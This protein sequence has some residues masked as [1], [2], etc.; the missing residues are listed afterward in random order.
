MTRLFL[1]MGFSILLNSMALAWWLHPAVVTVT[2]TTVTAYVINNFNQ[3][4]YCE[5][6]VYGKTIFNTV[7]YQWGAGIIEPGEGVK[8]QVFT[9]PH[10]PFKQ[11]WAQI[12]CRQM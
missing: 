3:N 8:L 5:G 7:L 6:N 10:V 9:H 1:G 4:I 11:G 2:S 12:K